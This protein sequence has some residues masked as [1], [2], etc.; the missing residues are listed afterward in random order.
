MRNYLKKATMAQ[1]TILLDSKT[2][3]RARDAAKA[4]KVSLDR[5]IADL[6]KEKTDPNWPEPV[7]CLAGAWPDFPDLE[8]IRSGSEKE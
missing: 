1:I 7:R 3:I 4:A 6:I 2:E 8:D 5:W